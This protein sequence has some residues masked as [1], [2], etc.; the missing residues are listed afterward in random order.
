ML[1]F[2]F[3][4]FHIISCLGVTLPI[5]DMYDWDVQ[6]NKRDRAS[7]DVVTGWDFV[8][9]LFLFFWLESAGS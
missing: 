2:C 5:Y 6:E 4:L 3:I 7:D 1:S 9:L 8:F